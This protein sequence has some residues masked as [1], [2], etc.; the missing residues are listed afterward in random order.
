MAELCCIPPFP[1]SPFSLNLGIFAH[2]VVSLIFFPRTQERNGERRNR[3]E[4]NVIL[5]FFPSFE[6]DAAEK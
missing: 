1:K 6:T 3:K 4:V 5:Y 2:Q